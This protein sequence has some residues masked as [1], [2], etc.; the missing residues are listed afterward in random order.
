MINSRRKGKNGEL[1]FVK[2]LE[3]HGFPARRG[4]QY[5][6]GPDSPDILC[7]LPYHWEI[8]NTERLQLEAA[9]AQAVADCPAGKTP[10]VA[11]KRNRGEWL[12]TLSA[13]DFL[14]LLKRLF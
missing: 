6:G 11:H 13:A 14:A 7:D 4:Q 3:E 12:V 10:I 2:L 8:K 5:R 1:S 9:Y